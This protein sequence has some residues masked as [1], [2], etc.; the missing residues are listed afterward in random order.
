MKCRLKETAFQIY[1]LFSGCFFNAIACYFHAVL[2][3][4]II[5]CY[6]ILNDF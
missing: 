3:D 1:I 6:L 2:D 5:M 4:I